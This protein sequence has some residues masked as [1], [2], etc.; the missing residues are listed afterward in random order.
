VINGDA[1]DGNKV[2]EVWPEN[3]RT[4]ELF[5]A[6]R[7]QWNIGAMGGYLGL[8]SEG[9]ESKMRLKR[10][11]LKDQWAIAEDLDAMAGEAMKVLNRKDD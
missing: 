3:W 6:C 10:I 5:V 1:G 2:F 9:V 8:R 4:L 7:Q 11:P